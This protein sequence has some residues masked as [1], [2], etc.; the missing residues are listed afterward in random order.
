[1]AP[2]RRVHRRRDQDARARRQQHRGGEVVGETVRHARDQVGGRRRHHDQLGLAR[3]AD[4]ADVE[5]AVRIEQV[6]EDALAGQRAGR[7]RRDEFPRRLRHRDAHAQ[8][9]LAQPPDQVERLV[10]RDAAADDEQN[11]LRAPSAP[12]V[13]P[14]RR[15]LGGK[16]LAVTRRGAQDEADFLLDRAAVLRRA[17]PQPLLERLVELADGEGGHGRKPLWNRRIIALIAMQSMLSLVDLGLLPTS[18]APACSVRSLP[19]LRG[20]VGE[21]ASETALISVRCSGHNQFRRQRGNDETANRM[22][23]DLHSE[24][25]GRCRV[26]WR[27]QQPL[28]RRPRSDCWPL[29]NTRSPLRRHP[30]EIGKRT[31][32]PSMLL[33][34]AS[35]VASDRADRKAIR[36][37]LARQARRAIPGR[38]DCKAQSDRRGQRARPGLKVRRVS[39]D[40]RGLKGEAGLQ[41]PKGDAGPPGS[42][43]ERGP[44]GPKGEAGLQ[45]PK[46][47]AGLQGL[48]G[49]AGPQGLKGEP[50]PPGPKGEPGASAGALRVLSGQA[51][52]AC[53]P[54]ETMISAYCVSSAGQMKSD[55]FIV[56]PR[57]ARCVGVL[58]PA[59]VIT[60]AK[61]QQPSGH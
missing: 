29:G 2:H 48:R 34:P 35:S 31:R 41:G 32:W 18:D 26:L 53:E 23:C 20:R 15:S 13:S 19:R 21:G 43:G 28:W 17:Q 38:R 9:A 47:E 60:C 59:V 6:G 36:G 30:I 57:G 37:P 7:E 33:Q 24:R 39:R 54:D 25:R 52:N 44:P 27:A 45:G 49:E 42:Q 40:L 8:A 12:R 56:P 4:V 16:R 14:R 50:G 10:R 51:S 22:A 11:L 3:E 61:L 46:G 1:M 55:P 5:L 58:N